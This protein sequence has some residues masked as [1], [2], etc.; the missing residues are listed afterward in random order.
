MKSTFQDK[1]FLLV[2][3]NDFSF[4]EIFSYNLKKMNLKLI[5]LTPYVF[6]YEKTDRITNFIQKNLFGNKTHK[7]ELVKTYYS[8]HISEHIKDIENKSVDYVLV[9]RPDLL[10]KSTLDDILR[11]GKKVV[12][13]QWDGLERFPAVFKYIDKFNKFYIF[14]YN[15]FTK[16][17]EKYPNLRLSSNFYFDFTNNQE[18]TAKDN[19]FY[20]GTYIENRI[21]DV[22]YI[23]GELEK[24]NIPLNIKLVYHRKTVP[25]I[26]KNIQFLQKQIHF[27]DY[28]NY[29]K[30]AKILLD[31]K[32]KEHNGLSLRFFEALKYEKKIITNNT[33]VVDYDFYNPN[34]IF[35][36]HKDNL[37]DLERFLFSDYTK[38]NPEI[39]QKYAFSSWLY[40]C[41]FE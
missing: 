30:Q 24:Y 23:V 35:I 26:N 17:K 11:V 4:Y 38:I 1:L 31:F 33:S 19:I 39:V 8:K 21:G 2:M 20:M 34:N 5:P 36:L 27:F 14:D 9:I 18:S 13:Y 6:K 37:A 32:M 3:P 28:L 16:Y 22:L 41:F 12:A 10:L 7:H 29:V 15:D 40:R 25:L